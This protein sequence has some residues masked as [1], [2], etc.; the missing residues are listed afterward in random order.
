MFRYKHGQFKD[1]LNDEVSPFDSFTWKDIYTL[2]DLLK[3][4]TC[5]NWR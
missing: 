3:S 2:K 4:G 1:F 5:I